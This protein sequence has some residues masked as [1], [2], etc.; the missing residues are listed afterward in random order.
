MPTKLWRKTDSDF[1]LPL[2][3][4]R[5]GVHCQS[6]PGV[7][8]LFWPNNIPCWPVNMYLVTL[9]RRG[10]AIGT[11]N[12]YASELASFIRFL[13]DHN[14]SFESISDGSFHEFSEFLVD[15]QDHIAASSKRRGGRQVNK[16]IRR[17][18]VFL[19]WYQT[20]FPVTETIIGSFGEGAKIT[21]EN[22]RFSVNGKS[23]DYMWHSSMVPNDVPQD[24]MP[25]PRVIYLNLLEACNLLAKSPYVQARS[26][27]LLK[28]LAD[29]GARRVEIAQLTVSDILEAVEVGNGKLRLITAKRKDGRERL[30]PIPA[31]TLNAV[32]SYVEVQRRVH[33][34]KLKKRKAI[35]HDNDWLFLNNSGHHLNPE[36]I[37]QDI[38]RLRKIAGISE[39]ATAHMLRH[40][41]ITIQVLERLK[42]Y[43]GQKLPMDIASTILTKVASM[44]GHK[45]IESLWPYIDL[46][47]EEMGVWDTADS[48]ISMRM[49]AEAAHRELR[50]IRSL[51]SDG[52]LLTKSE[53]AKIDQVLRVLLDNI[54]IDDAES[55]PIGVPSLTAECHSF[56]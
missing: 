47:F 36:T 32:L 1:R 12:T 16:I 22:R 54:E 7:R 44:T 9:L 15:E 13:F 48:V 41:W 46:A 3:A 50:E 30:V 53:I 39:K 55:E 17:S 18:L 33:V 35:E 21:I 5:T 2:Y 38:V 6:F 20:L 56:R 24:V 29:T 11:V 19:R 23:T 45:Q 25:M 37:T 10:C 8:V 49:N 26:R 43:I 42:S 31:T 27:T 34:R 51:H 40:R 52:S 28:L 4:H 14:A